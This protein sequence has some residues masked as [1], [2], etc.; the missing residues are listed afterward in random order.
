M[1]KQRARSDKA[2][3]LAAC[4]HQAG[5]SISTSSLFCRAC[6]SLVH[7]NPPDHCYP[8]FPPLALSLSKLLLITCSKL[9][10]APQASFRYLPMLIPHF[11][12]VTKLRLPTLTPS[13][14]PP[15]LHHPRARQSQ[16]IGHGLKG[17]ALCHF[18][19]YHLLLGLC[20][21]VFNLL[22]S[23]LSGVSFGL[24]GFNQIR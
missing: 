2:Y 19:P 1:I 4:L 9:C 3:W 22:L 15:S 24:K 6:S 13:V 7:P 14:L 12:A 20:I 16:P 5:P 8:F 17:S 23:L 18:L 21:S 11:S 10:T